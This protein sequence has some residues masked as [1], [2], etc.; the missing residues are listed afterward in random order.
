MKPAARGLALGPVSALSCRVRT[1]VWLLSASHEAPLGLQSGLQGPVAGQ[2]PTLHSTQVLRA[3]SVCNPCRAAPASPRRLLLP[4]GGC[5]VPG[6][7]SAGRCL[8]SELCL[9]GICTA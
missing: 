7:V 1:G 8:R 6:L 9:P 2:T 5:S 4:P 3:R